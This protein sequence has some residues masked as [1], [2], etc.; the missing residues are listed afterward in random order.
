MLMISVCIAM[1]M[2]NQ[3]QM[4]FKKKFVNLLFSAKKSTLLTV[5]NILIMQTFEW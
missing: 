5:C 4:L 2:T 1:Y 3:F